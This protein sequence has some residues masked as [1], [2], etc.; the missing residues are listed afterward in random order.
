MKAVKTMFL[1][2][3]VSVPDVDDAPQ[4]MLIPVTSKTLKDIKGYQKHMKV[5]TEDGLSPFKIK[6]YTDLDA[7]YKA[8]CERNKL[9]EKEATCL[10]FVGNDA[11]KEWEEAFSP[12][13]IKGALSTLEELAD[14]MNKVAVSMMEVKKEGV[15]F[16]ACGQDDV[17]S[18]S[19]LVPNSLLKKVAAQLEGV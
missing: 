3:L 16:L 5:M 1:V 8:P 4:F 11:K 19:H 2:S 17:W 12:R 6:C 13:K 10:V 18:S 14:P 15:F 7:M 9:N